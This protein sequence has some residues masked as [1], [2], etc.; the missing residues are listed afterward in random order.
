MLAT[1]VMLIDVA[2]DVTSAS[3]VHS[4]L[5][6]ITLQYDEQTPTQNLDFELLVV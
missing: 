4:F 3:V 1:T 6:T 5:Q 2:D